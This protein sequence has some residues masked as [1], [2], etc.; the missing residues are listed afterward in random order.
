MDIQRQRTL[1]DEIGGE[2][3]NGSGFEFE[4]PDSDHDE[5]FETPFEE[6]EDEQ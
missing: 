5:E 6:Q 1:L 4:T 3:L 2:P